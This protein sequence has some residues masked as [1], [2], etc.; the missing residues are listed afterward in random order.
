MPGLNVYCGPRLLA[1]LTME[2]GKWYGI[3]VL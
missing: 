2:E 1:L 3:L